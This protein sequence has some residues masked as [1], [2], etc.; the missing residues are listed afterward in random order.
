[1]TP[2]SRKRATACT[3]ERRLLGTLAQ[4]G[5]LFEPAAL[6]DDA[7]AGNGDELS[8]TFAEVVAEYRATYMVTDLKITTPGVCVGPR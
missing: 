7:G 5:E 1:M 3:E 8:K 2:A 4:H 6:D